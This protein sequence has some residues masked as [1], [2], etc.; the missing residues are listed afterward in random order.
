MD[1]TQP[2]PIGTTTNFFTTTTKQLN[3][4]AHA[5]CVIIKNIVFLSYST[6]PNP[7][8]R[9]LQNLDPTRPNPTRGSTQLMDNSGSTHEV[10]FRV[11]FITISSPCIESPATPGF[12]SEGDIRVALRR[13]QHLWIQSSDHILRW[14]HSCKCRISNT[15][16]TPFNCH[17]KTAEQR[18]IIEQYS[19]W[20]SG[21][22]WVG[23][24]IW[25]SDERTSVPTS[26]YSM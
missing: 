7:T 23:C 18:T 3:W 15:F 5:C 11:V 24:Y 22:W 14:R 4:Y 25:Y 26:Y 9:K 17:I 10:I 6:Q 13:P 19:D 16:L 12:A 2:N 20:Y 1:P 21:H 8:H